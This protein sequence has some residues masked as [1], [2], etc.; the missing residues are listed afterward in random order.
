MSRWHTNDADMLPERAFQ[1]RF[2]NGPFSHG[3]TLEGGKGGSRAPDPNPGLIRAAE[4]TEKV[5][6]RALDLQQEYQEWSKSFYDELKPTLQAL[7]NQEMEIA[8]ENRRRG[9]E[10]ADYERTTYRP[11]EQ[12]LVAEAQEYDTEAKREQLA[13][14]AAGDVSQA[15]GVVR[16]QAGRDMASRGLNPNSGRFAALNN[17]LSIQEALARAGSQTQA[18]NQAEDLGYAK[19]LDAAGLGRN[20]APNASTAYGVSLNASNQAGNT[21]MSAGNFRSNAYGQGSNML[22]QATSAYGSAGNIYGQEFNA[23]MQGYNAQQQ[24][25]GAFMQGLGSLAGSAIGGYAAMKADGGVIRKG[26]RYA[27][28]G[29]HEGKGP[30]SGPGGPVD[31]KVPALL[32]DGE[33]VLPADTVEKIGVKKLDQ[34]VKKTHTPAAVQR[35]RKRGGLKGKRK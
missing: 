26:L 16:Q 12:K 20:L 32:S 27:D 15:F 11:L 8:E 25:K 4:A 18:R 34:L 1:P 7:A 10:Y 24:A 14:R 23:R 29:V 3:M 17:Q 35:A 19:K 9:Q 21:A 13:S 31:D 22:G 6:M 33:Y 5:G 2:G 28:G 30:V